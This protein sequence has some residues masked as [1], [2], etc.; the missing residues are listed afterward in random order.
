MAKQRICTKCGSENY[1]G[2]KFCTNCGAKLKKPIYKRVWFWIL[3]IIAVIAAKTSFDNYRD[4]KLDWEGD[5]VLSDMLPNPNSKRGDIHSNSDRSLSID[6]MKFSPKQYSKYVSSC[7]EL[8]F[9]IDEETGSNSF[10]AY[11]E[12][13]Y[14]LRLSYYESKEEMSISLNAPEKMETI[15][16]PQS[17][18]AALLP[19]PK[20]TV[21]KIN[22]DRDSGFCANIGNITKAEYST[23]VDACSEAGFTV[24][25]EKGDDYYRAYNDAGYYLS[26]NYS[27]GNVMRIEIEAQEESL[28]PTESAPAESEEPVKASPEPDNNATSTDELRPDFKAAMDSYEAFYD[29]YCEVMKQYNENPADIQILT[30]YT[31]MMSKLVEMNEAFDA[32]DQSELNKAELKYYLEVHNR[33]MQKIVDVAG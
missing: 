4:T 31:G 29:E 22:W 14:M 20:S 1:P 30:K 7:Q 8:G 5:V 2:V 16:W 11:N 33:V 13:G 21:G 19:A 27:G 10:S 17:G 23:Y 9:V 26:L 12:D 15:S 3:I 18:L 24:D 25:Y 32:W 6:I 28:E